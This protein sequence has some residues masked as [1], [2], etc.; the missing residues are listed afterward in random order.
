MEKNETINIIRM[1]AANNTLAIAGGSCS[2]YSFGVAKS[3]MLRINMRGVNAAHRK[4]AN[5]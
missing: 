2:A 1:P 3:L 4:F 5:R